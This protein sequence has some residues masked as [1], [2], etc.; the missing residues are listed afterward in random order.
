M[1]T[2]TKRAS[3]APPPSGRMTVAEYE[4]LIARGILDERARVELIEGRIVSK[5]SK[6][7]RHC[8]GA[9]LV[10]HVLTAALGAAPGWLMRIEDP[11]AIPGRDSEPEPDVSIV[12]GGP[13]DY[14]EAQP[15]PDQV[16]L[17]VEISD[18]SLADDR[19]LAATYL[20]G[21]IPLYWIVNLVDGC[22]EVYRPRARRKTLRPGES[23]ELALDGAVIVRLDVAGLIPPAA[24]ANPASGRR[25]RPR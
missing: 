14:L 20:R 16:G 4:G 22:L 10:R 8:A 24:P 18:S 6:G 21:G 13:L 17:I 2:M 25:R 12:R 3:T 7:P 11:V 19:A 1:T 5:M 23:V 15:R 9:A